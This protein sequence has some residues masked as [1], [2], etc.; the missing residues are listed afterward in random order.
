MNMIN[1]EAV[2]QR[3][4]P[5]EAPTNSPLAHLTLRLVRTDGVPV[6]INPAQIASIEIVQAVDREWVACVSLAG[7][8]YHMFYAADV[9]AATGER[10]PRGVDDP[11]FQ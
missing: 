4:V 1:P 11:N 8:G 7:G 6:M 10:L 5:V 3:E 9:E 2:Y